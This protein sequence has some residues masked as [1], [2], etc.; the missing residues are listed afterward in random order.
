MRKSFS[1]VFVSNYINHHQIPFCN[2]MHRLLEGRF[3]FIQTQAMEEERIQMGWYAGER[4]SYVRCFYEEESFCRR[5]ISDCDIL[6]FGGTDDE[7][8]VAGRLEAGRPVLRYS[9]RLYKT[10]QWKA[11]S[12]RGLV[13]KYRD[14]TRYRRSAVYLLCAGAYVASDF[15]IVRA[16]PGKIY[17]WGYFPETRHYDPDKL[18]EG[19]GYKAYDSDELT[20]GRYDPDRL[21]EGK[22]YRAYDPDK[23]AEGK[24]LLLWAARMIG[25]KH[26]EL[27]VE[28]ARHL[29]EKGLSFH[30]DIIGDGELKPEMEKL[31][32]AY[33]LGDEVSFLG[34]QA[35]ETVR[36]H[37]EKADIF[38][39]TSDRNEGWGAVAN[40]AMNSGCALVAGHMIGSV[41]FLVRNG[42]NGYV[43]EDG[44]PAQ[45]F[46]M[47]EALVR[48]RGLCRRLGRNAYNTIAQAWNA[49]SAA[50]CLTEL[51][52]RILQDYEDGGKDSGAMGAESGTGAGDGVSEAGRQS[53]VFMPCM[54]APVLSERRARRQVRREGKEMGLK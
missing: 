34:Y 3:L 13:K 24:A 28:T 6:L 39:F 31:A 21:M 18:M 14:H 35:P 2:A 43:Y 54:P 53:G 33:G 52:E 30:I 27:A 22:G 10:G 47:T 45:L 5:A 48:D 8:Y 46:A 12:P 36:R 42:E 4:P 44:R 19:K 20:E 26:P 37:M 50:E 49:E 32:E 29:K 23:P 51:M 38:L 25:W 16:Y 15:H 1:V 7:S 17:C 40:E 41:P 9:E 11:V